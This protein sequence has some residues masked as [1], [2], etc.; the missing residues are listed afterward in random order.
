MKNKFGG[1]IDSDFDGSIE[2]ED[3]DYC[4]NCK[5]LNF[6]NPCE[7]TFISC[8]KYKQ[9]LLYYDWAI[10]CPDC[11]DFNPNYKELYKQD[12]NND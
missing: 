11:M 8:M 10:K 3:N 4:S 1:T 7:T 6:P 5:Y 12:E 9:D 2:I